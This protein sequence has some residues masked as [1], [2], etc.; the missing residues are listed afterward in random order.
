MVLDVQYAEKSI[1]AAFDG[2]RLADVLDKENTA[3]EVW[4]DTA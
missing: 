1:A 4:A 2:A 3:S